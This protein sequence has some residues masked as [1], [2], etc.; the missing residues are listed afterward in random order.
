LRSSPDHFTSYSYIFSASPEVIQSSNILLETT[1]LANQVTKSGFTWSFSKSMNSGIKS[2][3]NIYI[4]STRLEKKSISVIT[5]FSI[6]HWIMSSLLLVYCIK[7][8]LCIWLS[9][10]KY[11]YSF[12]IPLWGVWLNSCNS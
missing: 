7:N 5:E 4:V 10:G 11:F 1:I 9:R 6:V 3:I 8:R 12:C 2:N